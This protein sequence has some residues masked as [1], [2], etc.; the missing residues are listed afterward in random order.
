MSTQE[1]DRGVRGVCDARY[2]SLTYLHG[3]VFKA[4]SSKLR[5]S[6]GRHHDHGRWYTKVLFRDQIKDK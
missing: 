6:N 2:E 4:L 5:S 1:S 3:K